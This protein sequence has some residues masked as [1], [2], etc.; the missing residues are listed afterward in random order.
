MKAH[1]RSL[2]TLRSFNHLLSVM[3][4]GLCLYVIVLP[5]SPEFNFYLKKIFDIQPAL[6]KTNSVDKTNYPANNTLVIPSLNLQEEVHEGSNE[7]V[8]MK[9]LWHRPG[10]SSPDKESNTVIA[11][12]RFTYSDPAVFYHLDKIKE[13]DNI[14]LYW[15][16][17]KYVYRVSLIKEVLP[18]EVE[19]EKPSREPILTLY[20]CTPLWTSKNRLVVQANLTGVDK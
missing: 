20:T 11:G 5:L 16:K 7:A 13:G 17:T 3:V 8:L 9:G 4:V 15:D 1:A 14:I 2:L 19:V 18:T 10:T 6:V 12:H